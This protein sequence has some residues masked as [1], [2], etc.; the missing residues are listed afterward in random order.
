MIQDSSGIRLILLDVDGTLTNGKIYID[1]NNNSLQAFC[2][3]DGLGIAGWM[4]LGGEIAIITGRK[5]A[6]LIHR[7]NDLG[8]RHV[9]TGVEDKGAVVR[10]LTAKLGIQRE[11]I[12]AIGDDLNDISMFKEAALTFTPRDGWTFVRGMVD[13]VLERKGGAGAVREMIEYI[14]IRDGL[15]GKLEQLYL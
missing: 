6:S 11:N 12:A 7:A 10:E 14:L 4:K 13:V 9:Y 1:A 8:I 2:V 3:K 5:C 15:S